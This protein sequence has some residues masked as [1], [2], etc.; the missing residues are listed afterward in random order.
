LKDWTVSNLDNYFSILWNVLV[1]L[2][3]TAG[4][5]TDEGSDPRVN[6]DVKKAVLVGT[7]KGDPYS[8]ENFEN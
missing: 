3:R 2:S 8:P 6:Q 1:L 7:T 4:Y 5:A